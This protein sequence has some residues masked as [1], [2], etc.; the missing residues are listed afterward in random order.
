[1]YI[2]TVTGQTLIIS[3]RSEVKGGAIDQLKEFFHLKSDLP[4]MFIFMGICTFDNDFILTV[5]HG[6]SR[7]WSYCSVHKKQRKRKC[8]LSVRCHLN[9]QKLKCLPITYLNAESS[10]LSDFGILLQYRYFGKAGS[11]KT[12]MRK[13]ER[14]WGGW[15]I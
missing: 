1:M 15:A 9:D 2:Q 5:V 11:L 3:K 8:S 10:V 6:K 7:D 12:L 4:M 13:Y 14:C